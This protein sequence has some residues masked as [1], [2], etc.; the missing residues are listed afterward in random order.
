ML[1]NKLVRSARYATTVL[2]HKSFLV[3]GA[4][5]VGG[6]P[7]KNI[8]F[9]DLSKFSRAEFGPYRDKF[10]PEKIPGG[11]VE[12]NFKRAWKKHCLKNKHHTQYWYQPE[13]NAEPLPMPEVYVREMV[14]HLKIVKVK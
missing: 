10:Q 14:H 4:A 1:L 3:V 13:V 11:D 8:L 6:V 7:L 2:K 12:K 5:M 9:H